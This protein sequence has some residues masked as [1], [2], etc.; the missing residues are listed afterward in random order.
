MKA[1]TFSSDRLRVWLQCN[2]T[3]SHGLCFCCSKVTIKLW[4]DWQIGHI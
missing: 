4:G 3:S 1:P 2:G